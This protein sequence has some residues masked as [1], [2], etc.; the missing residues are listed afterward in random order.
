MSYESQIK[1]IKEPSFE[2]IRSVA[3]KEI[4]K[5]DKAKRDKLWEELKRGTAQLQTDEH[6]CQYLYSLGNMHQAKLLDAYKKLPPE[7][8]KNEIEVVDWGCGQAIG[9]IVFFDFI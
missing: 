3:S 9:S 5:L 8:F 6:M 7:F 2:A 4:L 1:A